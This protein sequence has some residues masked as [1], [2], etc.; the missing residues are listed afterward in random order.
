M[1]GKP[2]APSGESG[3]QARALCAQTDPEPFFPKKGGSSIEAK[4]ICR[5][6]E[7]SAACLRYALDNNERFGI[8]GGR[9]E[10]ER[11]SLKRGPRN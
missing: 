11:R 10:R 8:W 7:V 6:C 5:E 3:W 9:T 4:K 1:E 2:Y